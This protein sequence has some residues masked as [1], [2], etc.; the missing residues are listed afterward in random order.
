MSL[1]RKSILCEYF[2]P[3]HNFSFYKR[4][5]AADFHMKAIEISGRV[6]YLFAD[7]VV[8]TIISTYG[9]SQ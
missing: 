4:I 6:S 8:P 5:L 1:N 9:K 2:L 3:L 7:S